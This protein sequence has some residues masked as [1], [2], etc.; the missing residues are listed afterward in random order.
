MQVISST[1]P[2]LPPQPSWR[3]FARTRLLLNTL[4]I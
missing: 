2:A 1:F 4:D 3:I